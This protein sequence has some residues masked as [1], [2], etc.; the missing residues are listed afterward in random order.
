M[1]YRERMKGVERIKDVKT[2]LILL[3]LFIAVV[4]IYSGI[5]SDVCSGIIMNAFKYRDIKEQYNLMHDNIAAADMYMSK[6][7]GLQDIYTWDEI[8]LYPED[9]MIFLN[10][11]C[12]SSGVEI[13]RLR[14]YHEADEENST[15]AL[16]SEIEIECTYELLMSFMDDVKN[17]G[18]NA[19]VG[20]VNVLEFG[21]ERISAV[22]RLNFYFLN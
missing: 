2:V 22:A 6:D 5:L 1:K 4:M 15:A 10:D 20:S 9:V 14:F 7:A 21:G 19:A 8:C 3:A 13:K 17:T 16:T 11:L 12:E 18:V